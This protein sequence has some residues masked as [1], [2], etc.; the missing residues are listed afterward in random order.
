MH[1]INPIQQIFVF[2]T[3]ASFLTLFMGLFIYAFP[4][5]SIPSAA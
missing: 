3:A 1:S 4:T 2:L 5:R